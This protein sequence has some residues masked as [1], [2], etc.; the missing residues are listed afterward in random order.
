MV[1]GVVPPRLS[2]NLPKKKFQERGR[3]NK[4]L[5]YQGSGRD[6][7]WL[8]CCNRAEPGECPMRTSHLKIVYLSA[9]GETLTFE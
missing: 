6:E 2:L 4:T 1:S 3:G 7:K 9:M 8:N 5:M